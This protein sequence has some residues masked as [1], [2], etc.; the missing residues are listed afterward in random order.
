MVTAQAGVSRALYLLVLYKYASTS[1]FVCPEVPDHRRDELPPPGTTYFDFRDHKSLS[2]SYQVMKRGATGRISQL[3]M[4]S[5]P[6]IAILADRNP[7]SGV[8]GWSGDH[9]VPIP[10]PGNRKKSGYDEFDRNSFNHAQQGQHVVS[11]D[12][13]IRWTDTPYCGAPDTTRTPNVADNIW[14]PR[15]ASTAAPGFVADSSPDAAPETPDSFLW[16]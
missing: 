5:N 12:T 2:Y 4:G 7:I 6:D 14:T 15:F 11:I 8:D 16:P 13:S 3:W 1:N 10:D 9:A